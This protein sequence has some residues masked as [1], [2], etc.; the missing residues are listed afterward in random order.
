VSSLDSEIVL[1][2]VVGVDVTVERSLDLPVVWPRVVVVLR[3]RVVALARVVVGFPLVTVVPFVVL[4]RTVER[5]GVVAGFD[6]VTGPLVVFGFGVVVGGAVVAGR[7][8]VVDRLVVVGFGVVVGGAVVVGRLVVGD[9]SVVL[10]VRLVLAE[11][12]VGRE[13]VVGLTV[14]DGSADAGCAGCW[15]GLAIAA[16][17]PEVSNPTPS[18]ASSRPARLMSIPVCL[19]VC[20]SGRVVPGR[21]PRSYQWRAYHLLE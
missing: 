10:V 6:D 11:L 13:V 7:L 20:C 17:V 5:R 21:V 9:R 1:G 2:F 8:L 14:V 19:S 18:A 15:L 3:C 16:A 12:L 4:G